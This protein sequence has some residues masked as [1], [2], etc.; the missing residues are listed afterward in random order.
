[1]AARRPPTKEQLRFVHVTRIAHLNPGRRF[2]ELKG[3]A[4][5]MR[6]DYEMSELLCLLRANAF[7]SA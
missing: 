1:M 7:R 5:S 2:A 4:E 6:A 3:V